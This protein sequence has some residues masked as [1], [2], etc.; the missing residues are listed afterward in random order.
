M[1]FGLDIDLPASPRKNERLLTHNS[2][3]TE[4]PEKPVIPSASIG[5]RDFEKFL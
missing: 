2:L 4:L 5:T 3:P 1:V